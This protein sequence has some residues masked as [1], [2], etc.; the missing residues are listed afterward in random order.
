MYKSGLFYLYS[1]NSTV[2]LV[3]YFKIDNKLT[4]P[5][6]E[7]CFVCIEVRYKLNKPFIRGYHYTRA[8]TKDCPQGKYL[9]IVL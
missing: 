3:S 1:Y 5:K 7:V 8:I 6:C 9:F 2:E 4:I